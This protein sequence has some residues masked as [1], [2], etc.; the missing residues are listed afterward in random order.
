MVY[1]LLPLLRR[2]G[3]HNTAEEKNK[4]VADIADEEEEGTVGDEGPWLT[5]AGGM[6]VSLISA[7]VAAAKSA[8]RQAAGGWLAAAVTSVG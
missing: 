6:A 1:G 3:L 2:D 8:W 7:K 4:S 5:V